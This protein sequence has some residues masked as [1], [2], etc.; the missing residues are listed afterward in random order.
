M[1]LLLV[2]LA[3]S[4][5]YLGASPF[6]DFVQ[7]SASGFLAPLKWVPLRVGKIDFAPLAGLLLIVLL[8]HWAPQFLDSK[9]AQ[10]GIVIWPE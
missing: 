8:L 1:G 2:H 7:S 4:Y 9:L 10:R 6:W 5:V 3:A